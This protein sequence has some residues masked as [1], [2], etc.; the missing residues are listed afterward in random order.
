MVDII[1]DVEN[2]DPGH[3]MSTHIFITQFYSKF[4]LRT[5]MLVRQSRLYP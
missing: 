3:L 5:I 4:D 2:S 1:R